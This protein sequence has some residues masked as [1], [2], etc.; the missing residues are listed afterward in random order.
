MGIVVTYRS[1]S[2]RFGLGATVKVETS[3]GT[4]IREINNVASYLSSSDVRLHLGLGRATIV[5]RIEILWPSGTR[6][7]LEN[8]KVDQV[9]RIE[10][11]A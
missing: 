4:Q 10:E 6:Q 3:E 8:V 9:L 7:V 5:K 1:M 2:N 11:P